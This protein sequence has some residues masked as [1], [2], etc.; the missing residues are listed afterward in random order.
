MLNLVT[1][2]IFITYLST[3]YLFVHV[4]LGVWSNDSYRVPFFCLDIFSPCWL[5]VLIAISVT[6]TGCCRADT[7]AAFQ[8]LLD[9][10]T[11]MLTNI[12][13][14]SK[15]CSD[16]K[17]L[18]NSK[19]NTIISTIALPTWYYIAH[20]ILT[21]KFV[22]VMPCSVNSYFEVWWCHTMLSEF[23]CLKFVSVMPYSLNSYFEVCWCHTIRSYL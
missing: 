10:E 22:G 18:Q 15:S 13:I 7:R 1:K 5:S 23:L 12:Q 3:N 11:E 8:Y 4:T 9:R 19:W 17:F 2:W 14:N 21:V 20:W 16:M 6:L